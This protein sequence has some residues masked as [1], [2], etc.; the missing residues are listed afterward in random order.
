MRFL[1]PLLADEQRRRR[2]A[3]HRLL[4]LTGTFKAV[5]KF[6]RPLLA[7]EQRRSRL[8][9]SPLFMLAEAQHRGRLARHRLRILTV[10][11]KAFLIFRG[12]ML[13]VRK[14]LARHQLGI[15]TVTI[16]A[17]LMFRRLSFSARQRLAWSRW[18]IL[19]GTFK[20][21]RRFRGL[22]PDP[23]TVTER[24]R[25]RDRPD[26]TRFTSANTMP[27]RVTRSIPPSQRPETVT[28]EGGKYL[29]N[30]HA[31]TERP[32]PSGSERDRRF[33]R[34][35]RLRSNPPKVTNEGKGG[36]QER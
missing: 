31:S 7:V 13:A 33:T 11:I 34:L 28:A 3:R 5:M 12:R 25:E 21:V 30:D 19:R 8:V 6:L 22:V 20:A 35:L 29:G 10:T 32:S 9:T 1:R 26:P 23:L 17:L 36:P 4:I 16:K 15:L 2:L 24:K 18:L 14:N 27:Q